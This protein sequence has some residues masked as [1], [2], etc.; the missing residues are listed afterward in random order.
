MKVK[1]MVSS[2]GNP[3]ANQFIIMTEHGDYFQSY[4]TIIAFKD[5][6]GNTILDIDKWDYSQTTGRYRNDFLGEGIGETRRKINSGE[7]KL[8]NL[9]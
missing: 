5:K 7:Y 4:D 2:K 1:N 3:I 8:E 9:N 6:K